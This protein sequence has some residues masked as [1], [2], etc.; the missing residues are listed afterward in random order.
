MRSQERGEIA[1]G[2]ANTRK[3]QPLGA[4]AVGCKSALIGCM[5]DTL[6]GRFSIL[7]AES[8]CDTIPRLGSQP[9]LGCSFGFDSTLYRRRI[10]CPLCV[11]FHP[12]S[13]RKASRASVGHEHHQGCNTANSPLYPAGGGRGRA[14]A[15]DS[16][17]ANA[18]ISLAAAAGATATAPPHQ[19]VQRR[20]EQ[21]QA[22]SHRPLPPQ[23]LPV[24]FGAAR[25]PQSQDV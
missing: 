15:V 19:G 20:S 11:I 25:N 23:V 3:V 6:G 18:R 24:L 10:A 1:L 17:V 4:V 16:Q 13:V 7:K 5:S 12:Q 22:A 21:V 8:M 2:G 9:S 14:A